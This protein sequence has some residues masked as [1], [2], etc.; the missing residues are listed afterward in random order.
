MEGDAGGLVT[1]SAVGAAYESPFSLYCQ[2][3]ADPERRDPPDPF[4]EALSRRGAEHEEGILSADYPDMR[5]VGFATPREGFLGALKSM[6]GGAAAVANPPM[7]YV[8]AR[9]HG[10]P[11]VLER[12]YG[13]SAWGGHHYVVREIKAARNI[14]RW[15]VLQ[16]AF[17]AGMLGKVQERDPEYFLI[18]NGDGITERHRYGDHED[19]ML[20]C[21]KKAARI[22]DGWKPQAVYGGGRAP[23]TRLCNETAAG[24]RDASLV[25]GVGGSR[26]DLLAGAGLR[27]VDDVAGAPAAALRRI[28]GIGAGTASSLTGSARAIVSGRAV[29]RGPAPRLPDR[30]TEIFLDLEGL[31]GVFGEPLSDYLIGALVREDGAE[32]YHPFIAERRR[33]DRMLAS[34]L[35]FMDGREDYAVYHWHHYE[36]AHLRAMM[37]RH[38]LERPG[39][40]DPGTMLDLYQ[41]ATSA[42][43]FPTYSN[44]IKDI[45]GWMG[46]RWRHDGVGATS[47]MELYLAYA[48]D[49][50]AGAD[51]MRMVVEYNEDDCAAARVIRDWL[52]GRRNG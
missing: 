29:R 38:G 3:H 41:A 6:A 40:L 27:S 25:P 19:L 31:S 43:A 15:H 9:M 22:K 20:E 42:F 23:W 8:P 10:F 28:L 11:D 45:A 36:R 26:R 7:Y 44:S 34:F 33:E 48:D 13:R 17:Y 5:R 46:F 24:N 52:A 35:D 1:A 14:R 49:P 39:L 21:L 16:A 12:R 30:R 4:L 37:E 51:G 2:Y 50:E 32:T 18:T 47:A